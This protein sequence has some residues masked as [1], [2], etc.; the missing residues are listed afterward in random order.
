MVVMLYRTNILALVGTENNPIFNKN[1]VVIWDDYKKKK[2]KT[3]EIKRYNIC[4]LNFLK[5]VL[6]R[7]KFCGNILLASLR[8][9]RTAAVFA[10][11]RNYQIFLW[12]NTLCQHLC[13]K[14][15]KLT[16]SGM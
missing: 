4:K 16:A 12:R 1:K 3:R 7:R 2:E 13:P 9:R 14:P 8:I 10:R 15:A 11:F 6:T 5:K